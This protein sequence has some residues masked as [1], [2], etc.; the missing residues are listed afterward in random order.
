M[1]LNKAIQSNKSSLRKGLLIGSLCVCLPLQVLAASVEERLAKVE[2]LV[3]SQGL[4]QLMNQVDKL[5]L[6]LQKLHGE[7]EFQTHALDQIKQRQRE[8]YLDIDRRMQVLEAGGASG[9]VASPATTGAELPASSTD[10]PPLQV[11]SGSAAVD[12]PLLTGENS[13][14]PLSL[15]I[16]VPQAAPA[17]PPAPAD[18]ALAGLPAEAVVNS[19]NPPAVATTETIVLA[20][21]A[22]AVAVDPALAEETY[23]QAFNLLKT[24][25]HEQAMKEFASFVENY[26]DSSYAPNAQYWLGE[27]YYVKQRFEEA[28]AEFRLLV[29]NYPNSQKLTHSLLKIGYSLHELKQYDE[30]IKVLQDLQT[31]YP[32]TSAARYAAERLEAIKADQLAASAAKPQG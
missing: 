20:N 29:Q 11:L 6:E 19:A 7:I 4:I 1:S 23:K 14:A 31:R 27:A 13:A 12:R 22:P 5:Q 18:P 30:A 10:N 2:R 32:G 24:G 28:I 17:V 16:S 9:S 15:E 26:P 25:Q 21:Q 3:Q 8:L